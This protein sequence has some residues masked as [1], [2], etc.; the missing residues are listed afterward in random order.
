MSAKWMVATQKK[1]SCILFS[2]ENSC[3]LDERESTLLG[4]NLMLI[5]QHATSQIIKYIKI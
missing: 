4:Y 3:G 2:V 5:E 1:N